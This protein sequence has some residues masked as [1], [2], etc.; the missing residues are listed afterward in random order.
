MIQIYFDENFSNRTAEGFSLLTYQ[1]YKND[2]SCDSTR[3]RFGEGALD[4]TIIPN[5]AHE[6]AV[7]ITLDTKIHKDRQQVELCRNSGIQ[8]VFLQQKGNKYWGIIKM[9]VNNW[10]NLIQ[11]KSQNNE[12]FG[13]E[14]KNKSVRVL[15][16][17]EWTS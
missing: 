7:L 17:R 11:Y 8:I 16:G 15:W 5:L 3:N 4:E 12:A 13:L 9:I 6:K 10:D 14:F 2:V 1:G